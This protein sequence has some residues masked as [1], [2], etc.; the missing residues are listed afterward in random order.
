MA[1]VWVTEE[2]IDTAM[3][4]AL[5]ETAQDDASGAIVTFSGRV[6]VD[7]ACPTLKSLYL[8]HYPGMTERVIE[9][10]V[11]QA[12]ERF[13]LL[14]ANVIHRVGYLRPG[15]VIVWVAVA[16]MH[17]QASFDGCNYLMDFLKTEAPFWKKEIA[18]DRESW[19]DAK[20]SDHQAKMRWA[21]LGR[22]TARVPDPPE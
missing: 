3:E 16:A 12:Y 2:V 9:Q 10:H 21:G 17:R 1:K 6:R 11:Q 5:F 13:G 19:V 14:D 18:A 15:E 4:A 8:E 7:A 20:G 22:T